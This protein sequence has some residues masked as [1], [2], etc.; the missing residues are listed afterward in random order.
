MPT[1]KKPDSGGE[2]A[3][4]PARQREKQVKRDL[5]ARTNHQSRVN[6]PEI[7]IQG[8]GPKREMPTTENCGKAETL[9]HPRLKTEWGKTP[10][11]TIHSCRK[12]L[13]KDLAN[14]REGTGG[15]HNLKDK[16]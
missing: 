7:H 9:I 2:E 4:K 14:K 12:T 11:P 15:T 3:G 1:S 16:L 8:G 6:S 10:C 5:G 13:G